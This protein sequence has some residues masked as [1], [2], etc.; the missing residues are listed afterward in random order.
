MTSMFEIAPFRY[1]RAEYEMMRVG[2]VGVVGGTG[3]GSR[4]R[5]TTILDR[6]RFERVSFGRED[7]IGS[8]EDVVLRALQSV[9]K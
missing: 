6:Y 7:E 4:G 5:P 9:D 1:R 2:V 3:E 8:V